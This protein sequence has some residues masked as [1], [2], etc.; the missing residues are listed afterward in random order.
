MTTPSP[1]DQADR[2]STE[3]IERLHAATR[4]LIDAETIGDIATVTVDSAAD[5]LEYP[6]SVVWYVT[7]DGAAL[8]AAASSESVE[9]ELDT[10]ESPTEPI[11]HERGG[12][13]WGIY[14][15]DKTEQVITAD[16]IPAEMP[17][18]AGIAVLLGEYGL[19]TI[20]TGDNGT[21][22]ETDVR[23]AGVFGKNVQ[24][25]LSRTEREQ[26]LAEQRDDLEVLNDLVRHDIRNDL[27][28]VTAYAELLEDRFEDEDRDRLRKIRESAQSAVELTQTARDLAET[29]LQTETET[30]PISLNRALESQIESVRST[31]GN[32]IVTVEGSM[33]QVDVMADDMLGSVF[34]NVLKN[35]I[36]HN[37]K[38]IP[39]VTVSVT[40]RDGDVL[41]S[42][43]DNG[44]GVA[45]EAKETVFGKGEKGLESEGTGI[46]LYL[47]QTLVDRYGGSVWIE[48][49]D[50]AGAVCKIA[51]PT[52]S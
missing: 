12:W 45:D 32:A 29:M 38:D 19:L 35:A 14:E 41:V 43:A 18:Y 9:G 51:L 11:R 4:R 27:Q 13:L 23:L 1:S 25:V 10:P 46:G 22:S 47:V 34:R 3:Q 28:L 52:A 17:I 26:R 49:N 20:G 7:P 16:D 37:D 36:Q 8:E 42:I 5:I 6:Y 48:D 21:P 15:S 50:P 33:P 30:E 24:A 39:E 2:Q 44:P 31:S 40:E